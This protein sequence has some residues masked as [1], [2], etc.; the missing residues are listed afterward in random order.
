MIREFVLLH[1]VL[2]YG[3]TVFKEELL[4]D[5]SYTSRAGHLSNKQNPPSSID[6]TV[7]V[8]LI[9]LYSSERFSPGYSIVHTSIDIT[10]KTQVC[11]NCNTDIVQM[12]L[13]YYLWLSL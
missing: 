7:R 4:F 13:V 2:Q 5:F 11:A 12:R 6:G 3:C 10:Y 1:N 9:F 8:G